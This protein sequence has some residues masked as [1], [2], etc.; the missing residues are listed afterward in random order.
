MKVTD[1][2]DLVAELED[3][4]EEV[5]IAQIKQI[6]RITKDVIL[7]ATGVDLYKTIRSIDIDDVL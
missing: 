4:K 5:S 6:L 2:A 7:D 3:G 1:F